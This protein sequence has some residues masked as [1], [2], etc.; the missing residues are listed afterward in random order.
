MKRP[1]KLVSLTR[2]ISGIFATKKPNVTRLN[3]KDQ[4]F[5]SY[6][7]SKGLCNGIEL[8]ADQRK[9]SRK[10]AAEHLMKTGISLYM[11]EIVGNE[12]R[13]LREAN[14]RGEQY[15]SRDLMLLRRYARTNHMDLSKFL[16]NKI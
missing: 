8:V 13:A 11:G 6:F 7:F 15:R 14:E 1:S 5:R 9:C 3:H 4:Y 16:K 2:S 12:L 10:A